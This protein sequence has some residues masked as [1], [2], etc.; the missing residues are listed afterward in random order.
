[1][2]RPL[3]VLL[4]A[5]SAVVMVGVTWRMWI[6]GRL[7]WEGQHIT[8]ALEWP[9]APVAFVMSA[10]SAVTAAMLIVIAWRKF[11][12][13]GRPAGN[14]DGGSDNAGAGSWKSR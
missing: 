5:V 4:A 6:Q 11:T 12:G 9:I 1:L 2:R 8:G 10:L 13:L 7:M 3:A 14:S